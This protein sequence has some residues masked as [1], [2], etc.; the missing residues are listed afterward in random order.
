MQSYSA[1]VKTLILGGSLDTGYFLKFTDPKL[2][3][4]RQTVVRLVHS[5]SGDN[6]LISFHFY[7]C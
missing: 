1:R 5:F 3:M 7:F 2:Y 4:V 6:N